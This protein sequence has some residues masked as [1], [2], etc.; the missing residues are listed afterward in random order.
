MRLCFLANAGSANTR[1]WLRYFVCQGH[2]ISCISFQPGAIEGVNVHYLRY[3][4]RTSRTR[5]LLALPRVR[6]L[7]R[8]LA[9]DVLT[10]YYITSYGFLAASACYHP[11]VIASAG[12]DIFGDPTEWGGRPR[13]ILY[14]LVRRYA[15]SRAQLL[16]SWA[17][18][19]TS[20]LVELGVAPERI[21]TT[22]RGVDLETF[23]PA[24]HHVRSGT[25]LRVVTTRSLKPIYNPST[26]IEVVRLARDKGTDVS[27]VFVGEGPLKTTLDQLIVKRNLNGHVRLVGRSTPAEVAEELRRND[28]YISLSL[29]DGASSSLFEAMAAGLVPIVSDIPANRQWVRNGENGFLVDPG[30]PAP[31]AEHLE[32]ISRDDDFRSAVR[33]EN[34]TIVKRSLDWRHNMGLLEARYLALAEEFSKNWDNAGQHDVSTNKR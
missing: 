1:N 18:H 24:A 28:V 34:T 2:D 12:S 33:H 3:P 19:M 14:N 23:Y 17:P 9:P 26:I 25:P 13:E 11:L 15:L 22:P 4:T 21:L 31:I 20:R 29:S 16:T 5:Y 6:R 10:G 32:R 30:D 27:C 7:V 8:M